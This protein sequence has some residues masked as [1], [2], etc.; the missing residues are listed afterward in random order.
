MWYH[1]HIHGRRQVDYGIIKC[2]NSTRVPTTCKAYHFVEKNNIY[3]N[4]RNTKGFRT[5]TLLRDLPSAYRWLG[6]NFFLA[7]IAQRLQNPFLDNLVSTAPQYSLH[8]Q[9]SASITVDRGHVRI[10]SLVACE[11]AHAT[12]ALL[13]TVSVVS[14]CSQRHAR[15]VL[16]GNSHDAHTPRPAAFV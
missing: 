6:F 15:R 16:R 5:G 14:Q 11:V 8:N 1:R 10:S 9:Q 7:I 12:K 4:Y 3:K 13:V 2:I